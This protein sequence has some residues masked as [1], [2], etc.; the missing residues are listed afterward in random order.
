MEA[1]A[2]D[3]NFVDGHFRIAG[4]DRSMPLTEVAK[5]FYRPVGLPAHFG[6]GL[7][8]AGS[9]AGDPP[10]FPNGAHACEVEI[11]PETGEVRIDR[12]TVVD[13]VGVV[14]NPMVCE[15]QIDGGLAQ[16]FGQALHER[17]VYDRES[18]QLVTGSFADYTMPRSEDMAHQMAAEFIEVPCRTNPVGV[19]GVGEAGC[20]AAPPTLINAI[21]D[22]LRGDGV[23]HLDMP[24][25][26]SRVWQAMHAARKTA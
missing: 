12:Y 24:A 7:E 5:A 10:N 25:T 19:K 11:D 13:D 22:A 1:A 17:I 20:V 6:I 4:T 9:F 26:P 3:V 23:T 18:G 8:A 14:I 21:I 2:A 15:G 16:G